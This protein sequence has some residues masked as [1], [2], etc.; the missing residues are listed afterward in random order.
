MLKFF[1]L[2]K[3]D[4]YTLS[5]RHNYIF[6]CLDRFSGNP[7]DEVFVERRRGKIGVDRVHFDEFSNS[8]QMTIENEVGL[9]DH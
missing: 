3:T 8:P 1:N 2:P 9:R 6:E 7:S 4:S 5:S